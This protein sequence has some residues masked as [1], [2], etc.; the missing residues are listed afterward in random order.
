MRAV[1]MV[2]IGMVKRKYRDTYQPL[3]L[4]FVQNR[5][6]RICKERGN[7]RGGGGGGVGLK[8]IWCSKGT[9]VL[10]KEATQQHS[11]FKVS[12]LMEGF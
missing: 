2:M 11:T 10:M 9:N 6:L 5:V 4:H 8:V 7:A 3:C 12:S 1:Y